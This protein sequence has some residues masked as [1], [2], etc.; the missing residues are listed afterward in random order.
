MAPKR[1]K[2]GPKEVQSE[3]LL[4]SLCALVCNHQLGTFPRN[5]SMV[6]RLTTYTGIT[7]NLLA[8]LFL[9]HIFF[10]RARSRTTKFFQLS[11]YNPETNMYGCGTDDLPYVLFWTVM[12]TGMR[13]VVMEHVLDP[14]ARLGGIKSRKGLDRFKEQAWLIVYY[15]ASWSLGMVCK[16]RAKPTHWES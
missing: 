15:T 16:T 6:W 3:G 7:V 2:K 5:T 4:A 11:Y 10:P 13:V 14:L 1:S 9:T 12:F 8:L